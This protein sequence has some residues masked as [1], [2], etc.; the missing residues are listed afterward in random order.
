MCVLS[1]LLICTV[2]R[3]H[4]IVVEALYEME[5][6]LLVNVC[7]CVCVQVA[8]QVLGVPLSKIQVGET[9]TSVIPNASHTAASV[10]S[11]LFGGA[12]LV[13]FSD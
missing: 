4:I 8:S 2:L 3:A 10:S 5:L 6:L 12:V 7:V 11:E 13:C 1:H 9:A